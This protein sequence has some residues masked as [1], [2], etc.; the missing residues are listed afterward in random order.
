MDKYGTPK[1]EPPEADNV[2]IL[3]I[4]A[5]PALAAIG[6]FFGKLIDWIFGGIFGFLALLVGLEDVNVSIPF[7]FAVLGAI[8]GACALVSTILDGVDNNSR[9]KAEYYKKLDRDAQITKNKRWAN[10]QLKPVTESMGRVNEEI[11]IVNCKLAKV[12]SLDILPN[13]YR[14]YQAAKYIYDFIISSPYDIEQAMLDF[15]LSN[16]EEKLNIIIAQLN[17]I[18]RQN[19]ISILQQMQNNASLFKIEMQNRG[20]LDKL[21]QVQNVS[22]Q[23]LYNLKVLSV[24]NE[25][26]TYLSLGTYLNTLHS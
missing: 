25:V 2:I 15:R 16:I 9:L 11:E 22:E 6:Y 26:T 10:G 14:S 21:E 5:V 13:Q 12:Y 23:E 8:L 24:Q 4:I 3:G 7:V 20:I 19:D 1:I 17:E 18:I